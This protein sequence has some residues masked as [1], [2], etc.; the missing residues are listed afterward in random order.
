MDKDLR[1]YEI[2]VE[3]VT[4]CGGTKHAIREILDADAVSPEA[5][6]R[7]NGRF[8]VLEIHEAE[9]QTTILTGNSAGYRDTFLFTEA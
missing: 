3:R 9:D 1:S 7:E 5:Y 8:P 6:V 2:I 4:P